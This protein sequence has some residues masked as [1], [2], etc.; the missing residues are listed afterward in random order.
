MIINNRTDLDTA[1]KDVQAEFK[2]RLAAGINSWQWD[3]QWNLV[4]NTTTIEQFGFAVADFPDAPVPEQPDC[5]PDD[6]ALNQER[7]ERIAELK[8]MLRDTDYVD[9][10][11]Y[12]KE[13]PDV[14]ADRASWRTEIRQLQEQ[15]AEFLKTL[16]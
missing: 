1:P 7:L 9:L 16:T 5:N 12:D 13:K 2:Q 3:G 11:S 15:V 6:D 4:Q 14:I 8:Q 10:P